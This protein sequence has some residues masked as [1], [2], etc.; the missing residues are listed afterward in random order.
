MSSRRFVAKRLAGA[1]LPPRGTQTRR[2]DERSYVRRKPGDA[3]G[4]PMLPAVSGDECVAALAKIGWRVLARSDHELELDRDGERLVVPRAGLLH[5][6][7][8][9]EVLRRA[10]ITPLQ[11][12]DA[13][14]STDPP[15]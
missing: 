7:V 9:M 6:D 4:L 8:L 14:D 11:F 12:V 15:A 10:A 13:L 2:P 1:F 3:V 5:P